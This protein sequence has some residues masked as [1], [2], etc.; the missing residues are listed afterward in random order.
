[1]NGSHVAGGTVGALIA[2]VASRY[3]WNVSTD[4]ALTM[5]AAFGSVGAGVAHL[6]QPPGLIPRVKA[7]LGLDAKTEGEAS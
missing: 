3:G 2:F 5:G 6:F 4:E 1:M 7:A